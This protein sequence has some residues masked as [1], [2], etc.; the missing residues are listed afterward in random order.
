MRTFGRE[1][2]RTARLAL[3]PLTEADVPALFAI[4]SDPRAMQYWSGS[5]WK[6]DERARAM[7]ARDRDP[8]VV[9]HLR[10]G[11]ALADTSRLLGT[12]ALF[13]IVDQC[14]RAELGYM[15][16][17]DAWGKGYM[18]EALRA[19]LDFAF[20]DLGLNRLEADIHPGN[21]RS[22]RLL[23]RLGFSHEG[24]F[25]ERWIVDG[26]ASDSAMYGLLRREWPPRA[27]AN[28]EENAP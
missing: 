28:P 20:T 1:P 21:E 24:H 16:W 12:C 27:A 7:V 8:S 3:R 11:I 13:S 6:D 10:L 23:E 22:R 2:L 4:H 9:D 19:F 15:L 14:R 18:L 17:A 5:V 25:R 26:E